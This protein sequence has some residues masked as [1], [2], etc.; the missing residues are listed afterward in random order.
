MTT[1]VRPKG[2]EEGSGIR[3]P[4]LLRRWF[5]EPARLKVWQNK[6]TPETELR[7]YAQAYYTPVTLTISM[8]CVVTRDLIETQENPNEWNYWDPAAGS[9]RL[10]E[11]LPTNRRFA[12]D[13]L[14]FD[15]QYKNEGRFFPNVDFLKHT[16]PAMQQSENP[17]YLV[18]NPPYGQNLPYNFINRA[19]DGTYPVKRGIFLVS[20]TF[21]VRK[22]NYNQCVLVK[23]SP[24]FKAKFN[25]IRERRDGNVDIKDTKPLD[26]EVKLILLYS[27][28][29]LER[30]T[31]RHMSLCSRWSITKSCLPGKS[32]NFSVLTPR[33]GIWLLPVPALCPGGHQVA[34]HN[35]NNNNRPYARRLRRRLV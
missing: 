9:D 25:M 7:Y 16:I 13:L 2:F 20:A 19:F 26:Q 30:V 29:E 32:L 6:Y 15:F 12:S 31:S 35:D 18:A 10:Y 3:P 14:S 22:L 21:N 8:A 23:Q 5:P 1:V 33:R 34:G 4:A 24:N 27:H 11:Q 17:I 28:D